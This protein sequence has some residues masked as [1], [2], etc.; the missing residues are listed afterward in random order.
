MGLR[1]TSSAQTLGDSLSLP[2]LPT[3]LLPTPSSTR[4]PRFR[5]SQTLLGVREEK[6]SWGGGGQ[7]LFHRKNGGVGSRASSDPAFGGEEAA[8]KVITSIF[9]EKKPDAR[10][11]ISQ[12]PHTVSQLP[13]GLNRAS[14]SRVGGGESWLHFLPDSRTKIFRQQEGCAVPFLFLS[15]ILFKLVLLAIEEGC[16]ILV[17]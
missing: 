10:R 13:G 2:F 8:P 12:R 1:L 6:Q 15:F 3:Q 11:R 7:S 9:P 4:I 5:L 17:P 16:G 14:Y